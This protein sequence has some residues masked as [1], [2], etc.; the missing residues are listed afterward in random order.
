MLLSVSHGQAR[1]SEGPSLTVWRLRKHEKR[2]QGQTVR[3]ARSGLFI[4]PE[5]F[6]NVPLYR[7]LKKSCDEDEEEEE[8]EEARVRQKK[9]KEMCT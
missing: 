3:A 4:S 7:F 5:P 6:R 8:E 1:L 2:L 9:E